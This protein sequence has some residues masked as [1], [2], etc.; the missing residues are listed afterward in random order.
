MKETGRRKQGGCG[1]GFLQGIY[2]CQRFNQRGERSLAPVLQPGFVQMFEVSGR[3]LRTELC[4]EWG[5]HVTSVAIID[6][7]RSRFHGAARQL[8]T[9]AQ[10]YG[11]VLGW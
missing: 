11:V 9:L 5:D 6:H 8:R 4:D 2:S 7:S 3:F 1:K 10:P